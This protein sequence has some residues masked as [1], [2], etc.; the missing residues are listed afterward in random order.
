MDRNSNRK[1]K[2]RNDKWSI[3]DVWVIIPAYNEEKELGNVLQRTKRYARNILVVDDGSTDS[4]SKIA[5]DASI[6]VLR[7][8]KNQGKGVALRAGCD[9]AVKRGARI[10][11]A[12]DADGQHDPAYIP[13]LLKE[14]RNEKTDIVYTRRILNKSMPFRFTLG[15]LILNNITH[16]LFGI[17]LGDTQCGFRAFTSEAYQAIRWK[18]ERYAAMPAP[19]FR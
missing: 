19:S 18:V 1:G 8:N 4:T 2:S 3:K 11:V 17:K 15:N 16:V 10:L 5:R 13:T 14:L 7:L 12:M 9:Y 6:H